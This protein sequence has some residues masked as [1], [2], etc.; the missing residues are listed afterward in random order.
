VSDQET[1]AALTVLRIAEAVFR[2]PPAPV[3]ILNI[4]SRLEKK[5]IHHF[6]K[7]IDGLY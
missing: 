4:G 7:N 2:A 5:T 3:I 6:K 1:Q